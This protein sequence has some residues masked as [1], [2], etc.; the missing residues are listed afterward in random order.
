MN[1][2]E[3]IKENYTLTNGG[4]DYICNHSGQ[5]VG[6]EDIAEEYYQAKLTLLGISPTVFYPNYPDNTLPDRMDFDGCDG[7]YTIE[8]GVII[9]GKHFKGYYEPQIGKWWVDYGG[10]TVGNRQTDNDE[11]E[12]WYYLP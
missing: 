1:A 9:E 6:A 2:T 4:E 12:G 11:I 10:F 3:F 8:V 5:L 7:E